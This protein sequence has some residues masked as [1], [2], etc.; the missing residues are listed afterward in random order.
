MQLHPQPIKLLQ[1]GK[2]LSRTAQ[3]FTALGNSKVLVTAQ[4]VD[5]EPHP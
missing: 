5:Y 2:L 1:Q 4:V 3:I